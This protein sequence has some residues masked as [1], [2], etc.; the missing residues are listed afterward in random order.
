MVS[1]LYDWFKS[2]WGSFD[3]HIVGM[4]C[5]LYNW[6]E[7]LWGRFEQHIVKNQGVGP[8]YGGIIGAI[9]SSALSML[10]LYFIVQN[11]SD[12]TK[13]IDSTFG[14]NTKYH[15]LLK[16][17]MEVNE[18]CKDYPTELSNYWWLKYFDLMLFEYHF[19]QRGYVLKDR[20]AEWMD[21]RRFEYRNN[22]DGTSDTMN[23]GGK[24]YLAAWNEW[25]EVSVVKE[26]LVE[27][28]KFLDEVHNA[29]DAKR[30]RRI[31]NRARWPCWRRWLH[32]SCNVIGR[33]FRTTSRAIVGYWRREKHFR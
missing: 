18:K 25:K 26:S 11:Y 7:S 8:V 32:Q 4:I 3:E 15:E 12:K 20:F 27:F 30:V 2:L 33:N 28:V 23:T 9:I 19:Y 14:F 21:W 1:S 16:D 13:R 5:S 31:V 24:S 6:F 17:R 10:I 29:S 22:L